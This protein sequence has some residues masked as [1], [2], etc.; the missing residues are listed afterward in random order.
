MRKHD[1][2]RITWFTIATSIALL[3]FCAEGKAAQADDA[4]RLKQACAELK[5]LKTTIPACKDSNQETAATA[6]GVP[7]TQA[8]IPGRGSASPSDRTA[9]AQ[10]SNA[11]PGAAIPGVPFVVLRQDQY[12]EVSYIV[13]PNPGQ[14]L[15]GA[16]LSYTNDQIAKTQSAQIKG[17]LGVSALNGFTAAVGSCDSQPNYQSRSHNAAL[18][19]YGFGGFLLADGTYSEPTTKSEKSAL[20][21]GLSADLLFCNS[22]LFP[23]QDFQFLPY[24]QTDF[25]GK[26]G[27][28]GFDSIWEPTDINILLGGRSDVYASKPFAGYYV[29]LYGEA[30]VFDVQNAGLTNFTSRTAYAFLGGTTEVRAVLFE[31]NP[32]VPD[33]LCGRISLIGT[34]RYM[35]D[36]I[37]Q[38]PTHLY[39]AEIDYN[40]FGQ[41]FSTAKCK[42]GSGTVSNG[43]T[44]SVALIYNNGTDLATFVNQNVYKATF[45]LSY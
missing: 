21:A 17:L 38:K 14:V 26:A 39:G 27:M 29:R 8:T 33:V 4:A 6:A 31:N 5:R 16:S 43:A 9:N 28:A 34:A 1:G 11:P 36:A 18:A 30:N 45:K 20:R 44:G 7:A 19:G 10:P 23:Y 12:D 37:A 13:G 35:W 42:G 2:P 3:T 32:N 40:L 15:Q 25:R 22:P 24:V 41:N